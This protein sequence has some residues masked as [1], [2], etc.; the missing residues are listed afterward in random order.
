MISEIAFAAA[1]GVGAAQLTGPSAC[2]WRARSGQMKVRLLVLKRHAPPKRLRR[3][4]GGLLLGMVLV[5]GGLAAYAAQP[6][7]PDHLPQEVVGVVGSGDQL[8]LKVTTGRILKVGDV[9][10]DGWKIQ[11][12]TPETATLVKDAQHREIGLNPTGALPATPASGAPSVVQVVS[13]QVRQALDIQASWSSCK[14]DFKAG[15]GRELQDDD[16]DDL[17]GVL[18]PALGADRAEACA[19]LERSLAR[20]RPTPEVE[21]ALAQARGDLNAVRQIDGLPPLGPDVIAARDVATYADA[22]FPPGTFSPIGYIAGGEDSNGIITV[23]YRTRA[24]YQAATGDG[25]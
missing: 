5:G 22:D 15:A 21:R 8:G 9:Y 11:S 17:A 7:A 4:L 2:D 13:A 10:A 18:K 24:L 1:L 3:T 20:L 19:G 6:S 25:S 14:A 23:L 16:Y 12:V